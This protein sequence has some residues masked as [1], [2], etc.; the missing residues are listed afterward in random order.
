MEACGAGAENGYKTDYVP[1]ASAPLDEKF[2]VSLIDG[3]DTDIIGSDF[4]VDCALYLGEYRHILLNS[5]PIL[6]LLPLK[7][8]FTCHLSRY[9]LC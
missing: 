5:V 2:D 3:R 7:V 9:T 1:V 4:S 6:I 8:V